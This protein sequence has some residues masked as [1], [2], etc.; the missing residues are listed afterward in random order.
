MHLQT[1]RCW[2]L[3]MPLSNHNRAGL[4]PVDHAKANREA[5][6]QQSRANR[7]RKVLASQQS[8]GTVPTAISLCGRDHQKWYQHGI[9]MRPVMTCFKRC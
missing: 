2:P 6:K 9:T 1:V 7:E 8:Q 5:I 4:V 3:T